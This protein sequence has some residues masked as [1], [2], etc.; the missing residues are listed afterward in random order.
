MFLDFNK[1][2]GINTQIESEKKPIYV[3]EEQVNLE[4]ARKPGALTR[5]KPY[6]TIITAGIVTS[7]KALF[8]FIN[9]NGDRLL[10]AQDDSGIKE[11]IETTSYAAFTALDND[12]RSQG[13]SALID[14][15]YPTIFENVLRSGVG[16]VA[17]NVNY[18]PILYTYL[19]ARNRFNSAVTITAGKY[20]FDQYENALLQSGGSLKFPGLTV[21]SQPAEMD[22]GTHQYKGLRAGESYGTFVIYACPLMDDFQRGFPCMQAITTTPRAASKDYV[23][24]YWVSLGNSAPSVATDYERVTA[25][26]IYVAFIP[27]RHYDLADPT[28]YA[29]IL[30]TPAYFLER[31]NL[32]TDGAP[33]LELTGV[34][35][36]ASPPTYVEFDDAFSEW[37]TFN[38]WGF[39][40]GFTATA[41]TY[42]KVLG[43]RT[44]NGTKV[45]YAIAGLDNT[46]SGDAITVRVFPRWWLDSGDTYVYPIAYDNEYKIL[47]AEMFARQGLPPGDLGISDWQYKYSAIN[48]KRLLICGV[49]DHPG[50]NYSVPYNLD[51]IPA[52]NVFRT[53]EE[54]LGCI[55]YGEN[56]LIFSKR[57]CTHLSIY[58]NENTRQIDDYIQ[59]TIV[60]QKAVVNAG[61]DIVFGFD[62]EGPWVLTPG[63]GLQRIGDSLYQWWDDTLSDT[64][65]DGCV[66]IYNRLKGQV[67][68]YFPDYTTAPYTLGLAF[69]FDIKAWEDSKIFPWFYFT[70][71]VT[72]TA[73]CTATDNHTLI[74]DS[75]GNDVHDLSQDGGT[76][77]SVASWVKLKVIKNRLAG[78]HRMWI[79]TL[80]MEYTGETLTV[81]IYEDGSASATDITSDL[82]T[83]EKIF[84][85]RFLEEM[86]IKITPAAGTGA[87]KFVTGQLTYNERTF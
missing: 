30:E 64:V 82:T 21:T 34:L 69:V 23:Y 26:D 9:T 73:W 55:P 61:K 87:F 38:L 76:D 85:R 35:E 17:G 41:A 57:Y 2:L 79:D 56:F 25:L 28:I 47:G 53:P 80:T 54:P 46:D 20:L 16:V 24:R 15:L 11:S 42:E 50:G 40:A 14:Q 44:E 37:E 59:A 49:T 58:G 74:G 7:I 68:Y 3:V 83:N 81:E 60:S 19:A 39:F 12:N 48:G 66:I 32:N 45:Q 1:W 67:L 22:D 4:I 51:V 86:Q 62:Y 71:D 72:I 13:G 10:I 84:I 5:R 70:T 65:K 31:V 63:G 52:L 78:K 36:T 8:E 43:A 29:E 77:E 75:D 6:V 27:D 18:V 33:V